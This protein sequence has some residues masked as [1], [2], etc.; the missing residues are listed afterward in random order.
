MP[1]ASRND[2]CAG[3]SK[4]T[5]SKKISM[6]NSTLANSDLPESE[7][8]PFLKSVYDVY[9]GFVYTLCLRLL[10][11]RKAA[12]ST[13]VEVFIRFI[14]EQANESSELQTEARLRELAIRASLARP[15]RRGGKMIR[16]ALRDLSVRLRQHVRTLFKR[17]REDEDHHGNDTTVYV[18]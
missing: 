5:G 8:L 3:H 18:E 15:R 14:H 1:R 9:G 2:P 13:T 17:R 12:E 16:Q 6:S 11:N 4:I 10:A 7:K